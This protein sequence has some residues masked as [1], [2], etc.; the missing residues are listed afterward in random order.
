[1]LINK[2]C[3]ER[4]RGSTFFAAI[5][6]ILF[7]FISNSASAII[8]DGRVAGI[9]DRTELIISKPKNPFF[10]VAVKGQYF[11]VDFWFEFDESNFLPTSSSKFSREYD[12]DISAMGMVA[13][14]GDKSFS[15]SDH[16]EFPLAG[17][18]N[19]IFI[20]RGENYPE[21]SLTNFIGY[22]AANPKYEESWIDI[23]FGSAVMMHFSGFDLV[24]EFSIT[25]SDGAFLG[26]VEILTHGTRDSDRY[27]GGTDDY[28]TF[29]YGAINS[30][31]MHVRSSTVDEPGSFAL[32]MLAL[33]SV[34]CRY[35]RK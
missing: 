31:D 24:Q 9:I 12:F 14:V 25:S 20:Y 22:G 27:P 15:P 17:F 8:I 35:C 2:Y 6:C 30:I 34:G 10:D 13:Q 33:L 3:D 5:L 28:G 21:F 32:I 26:E 18:R 23:Y 7:L 29:V 1:M 4:N 19:M 16:S 11:S